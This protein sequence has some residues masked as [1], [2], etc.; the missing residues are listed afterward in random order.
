MSDAEI[1]ETTSLSEPRRPLVLVVDD[2]DAIREA[3]CDFSMTP[4]S[5]PSA[6]ATGWRL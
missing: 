4:G 2:D 5:R 1:T 6:P 3:L